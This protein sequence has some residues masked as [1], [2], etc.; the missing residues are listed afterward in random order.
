ME[1]KVKR[2]NCSY[3]D[4]WIW[5]VGYESARETSQYVRHEMLKKYETVITRGERMESEMIGQKT[6]VKAEMVCRVHR[7]KCSLWKS[8]AIR[9][10]RSFFYKE[11]KVTNRSVDS[12]VQ[13]GRYGKCK[14]AC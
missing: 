9:N 12:W 7:R 8:P 14:N 11:K 13:M 5:I 3:N 10:E 1:M 6:I 4:V 2:D